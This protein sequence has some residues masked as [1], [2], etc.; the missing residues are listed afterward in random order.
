PNQPFPGIQ[1]SLHISNT[2]LDDVL[3]RM[4][5]SKTIQRGQERS[6]DMDACHHL[7]QEVV[8]QLTACWLKRKP[9]DR[10]L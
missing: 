7:H 5:P 1:Q 8:R 4:R 10:E 2:R 6:F 3:P 9:L